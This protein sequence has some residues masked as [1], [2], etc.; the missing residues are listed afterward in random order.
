MGWPPLRPRW[1]KTEDRFSLEDTNDRYLHLE[2]WDKSDLP[3][4]PKW[5][6]R[7][8][9]SVRYNFSSGKRISFCA[10]EWASN[11]DKKSLRYR[12]AHG[13]SNGGFRSK[14]TRTA[15]LAVIWFPTVCSSK[16]RRNG[17][18]L[19]KL[20]CYVKHMES[21]STQNSMTRSSLIFCPVIDLLT[22]QQTGP[23]R[24]DTQLQ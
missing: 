7:Y 24:K 10:L 20:S 12:C 19:F 6:L 3:E 16:V 22:E 11:T 2:H 1:Q 21:L 9:L 13:D 23:D 15:K 4:F 5:E 18:L 8:G 17:C 14:K